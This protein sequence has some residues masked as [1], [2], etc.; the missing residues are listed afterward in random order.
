[1]PVI[2][3]YKEMQECLFPNIKEEDYFTYCIQ[4]KYGKQRKMFLKTNSLSIYQKQKI[5]WGKRATEKINI[6][7]GS[8]FIFHFGYE[9]DTAILYLF[10]HQ[11]W[12]IS[13]WLSMYRHAKNDDIAKE[14]VRAFIKNCI[15]VTARELVITGENPLS[16]HLINT[17]WLS[18]TPEYY[19]K[20]FTVNGIV[21]EMRLKQRRRMI[22]L[23][24]RRRNPTKF[25]NLNTD[26]SEEI[27][28]GFFN[29]NGLCVYQDLIELTHNFYNDNTIKGL[30]EKIM[31]LVASYADKKKLK[32]LITD[33][34]NGV[35]L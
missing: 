18:E 16:T 3:L 20:I 6:K 4:E 23:G 17:K 7:P 32:K 22:A 9:F 35:V 27:L 29:N 26:K 33:L 31:Y 10:N 8:D 28:I 11:Y 24:K 13:L 1:M 12:L 34:N 19:R 21:R 15:N 5:V 14:I 30:V 2:N 25:I